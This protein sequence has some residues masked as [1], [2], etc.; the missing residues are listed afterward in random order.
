MQIIKVQY[1]CGVL[2]MHFCPLFLLCSVDVGMA[3][4]GA[5]NRYVYEPMT[6]AYIQGLY[7]G[8]IS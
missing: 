5:Y 6:A 7:I 8:H 3:S 1:L 2:Y 4:T